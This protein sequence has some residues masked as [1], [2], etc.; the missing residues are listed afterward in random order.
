MYTL[1][2]R[3]E[4]SSVY[5]FVKELLL[6]ASSANKQWSQAHQDYERFNLMLGERKPKGF[7]YT[8][9]GHISG[10]CQAVNYYRGSEKLLCKKVP[11]VKF[12]RSLAE[13]EAEAYQWLPVSFI[14]LPKQVR[15]KS[16]S[17]RKFSSKYSD[18]REEL[19]AFAGSCEG[20]VWIAK[21]SSG[22]KGK[23]IFIS[24]DIKEILAFVDEQ[25]QGF[26]VQKY[27]ENPL[28][29]DKNRKFDIRHVKF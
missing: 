16:E 7:D 29:L 24:D 17:R 5:N 15:S 20:K 11:L 21:S 25:T 10:L 1:V 18:E 19:V 27:I 22:A 3:D 23:D 26:V 4:G 2:N 28:L 14:I 8:R 12:I 13:S 6:T 9:I